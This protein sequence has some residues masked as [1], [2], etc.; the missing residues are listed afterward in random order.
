VS[1]G[2]V[3][4]VVAGAFFFVQLLLASDQFRIDTIVVKGHQRLNQETVVALSDVQPGVSTFRLDLGLI[5]RK[6]SENPWVEKARIDRVFPRQ[7]VI[8]VT[9]RVP[10]AIVNLGY[11]YYLDA[12]GEI[13]KVLDVSDS[14]DYPVVTGFDSSRLEQG[15]VPDREGLQTVVG[16]IAELGRREGFNLGQ[17]SEIH[18]EAGGGLSL[19]TLVGGVRIRL[20]DRDHAG[21][22]IGWSGF[23][24]CCNRK[25]RC[26]IISILM[27]TKKSLCALNGRLKR[28]KADTKGVS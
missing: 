2:S 19:Y 20:G 9:E 7:V 11:L 23:M 18:R 17:V 10:V 8:T 16:L 25:C 28:P 14:L 13:F 6:I 26:W 24:P 5:G 12:A 4:L 3:V 1:L 15:D 22:L 27:L 21:N